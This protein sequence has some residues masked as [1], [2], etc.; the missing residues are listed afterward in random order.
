MVDQC[1]I[2]QLASVGRCH[3]LVTYGKKPKVG[4]AYL[5]HGRVVNK[6]YTDITAF[7]TLPEPYKENRD[8]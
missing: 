3:V 6:R 8:A 2:P 4:I 5:E 7:A 1:F